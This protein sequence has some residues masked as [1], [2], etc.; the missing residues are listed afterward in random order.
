MGSAALFQL[1]GRGRAALGLDRY[2]PP[3][4]LGST[5]G[6]SRIIREAYFEHPLYVP[7][8]RRAYECWRELEEQSEIQVYRKTGGLMLGPENGP[9]VNGSRTS[10]VQHEIAHRMMSAEEVRSRFPG[11]T[12]PEDFIA[13]WEDRAG[14]LFPEAAVAAQLTLAR[15]QGASVRSGTQLIRW[16]ADQHGVRV[17]TGEGLLHA[18]V[19]VLS[20]GSWIGPLLGRPDD[21]FQV[22][23]QLS[24]WFKPALDASDWPVALWE[25]RPGGLF[26]TL[27]E[28][29][30]RVKAGLHHEG[31]VVDPEAVNRQT[32]AA[33]ETAVRKLV[34]RYQPGAAGPLLNSSV[35]L[36][37]NTPDRHFVIDWH[38]RHAN[39]LVVSPCSGHGF[40][41]SAAIGEIVA[42]LVTTGKSGFDLSPFGLSRF[43]GPFIGG[44]AAGSP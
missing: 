38:P 15:R 4:H 13:L 6:Q 42:D 19:L 36:Y 11:F 25:Y 12:P 26:Y 32:D 44:P 21:T 27:P 40:K 37:T 5:H 3:H 22:E 1:A 39:V 35:C 43:S 20:V 34:A 41:F 24:H 9:L 33:E 28:A 23:R 16:S 29:T 17:E 10:A 14:L 30:G 18:R 31:D 2:D 8:V 7:L